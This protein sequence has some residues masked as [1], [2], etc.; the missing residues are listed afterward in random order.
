[1]K[2]LIFTTILLLASFICQGQLKPPQQT[3][4]LIIKSVKYNYSEITEEN[5]PCKYILK[6][7]NSK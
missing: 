1:M 6:S 7:S 4:T 2:H 3:D 5:W